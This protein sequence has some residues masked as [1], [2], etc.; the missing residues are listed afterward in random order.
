M[1][2]GRWRMDLRGVIESALFR[3]PREGAANLHC[4]GK[5]A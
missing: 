5:Q 3:S 1:A 2:A 4:N